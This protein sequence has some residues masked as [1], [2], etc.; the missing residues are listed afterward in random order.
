MSN[1]TVG[2]WSIY[3]IHQISKYM[4]FV[5][6]KICSRKHALVTIWYTIESS[7]TNQ[8]TFMTTKV[9]RPRKVTIDG[10]NNLNKIQTRF[11]YPQLASTIPAF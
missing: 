9:I 10:K 6:R 2:F 8:L 4:Y 1:V 5:T 7:S 11:H 3:I